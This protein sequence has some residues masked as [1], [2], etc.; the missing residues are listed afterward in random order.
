MALIHAID[1]IEI[2]TFKEFCEVFSIKTEFKSGKDG[3]DQ[4]LIEYYLNRIEHQNWLVNYVYN[5]NDGYFLLQR[6]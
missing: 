5:H 1:S 2:S 6:V 3:C 4:E